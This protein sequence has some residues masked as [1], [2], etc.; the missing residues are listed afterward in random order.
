MKPQAWVPT[1]V[2][3]IAALGAL[4]LLR[5]MDF[6]GEYRVWMALAAGM[7]ATAIV[8]SKMKSQGDQP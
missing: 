4:F 2:F 1:V 7:L 5:A 6:G 8:Q 3:L